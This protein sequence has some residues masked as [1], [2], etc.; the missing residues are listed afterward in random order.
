MLSRVTSPELSEMEAEFRI[1][2]WGEPRGDL[3]AAIVAQAVVNMLRDS[4]RSRPVKL[5]DFLL[6]FGEE[7]KE[8]TVEQ[9][10]ELMKALTAAWGGEVKERGQ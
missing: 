3:Q 6:K 10:Q 5:S 8:Q 1:E 4:R 7:E 2:P 9:Q